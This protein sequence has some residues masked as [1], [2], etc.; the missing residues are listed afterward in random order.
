MHA[1]TYRSIP[2]L[3]A[4]RCT[5]VLKILPP[6]LFPF[7]ELQTENACEL[8]ITAENRLALSLRER[9]LGFIVKNAGLVSSTPGYGSLSPTLK[10]ELAAAAAGAATATSSVGA[11]TAS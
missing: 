3:A 9:C 5:L 1:C 8:L 2:I 11:T 6:F 10:A 4:E 7:S